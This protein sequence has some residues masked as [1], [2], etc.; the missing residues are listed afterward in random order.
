MHGGNTVN[1]RACGA[2]PRA[3]ARFCDACGT[4]L[5]SAEP[6]AEYKQVTV[7]FAD[8]VRS[9]DLAAEVDPERFRDIMAQVF[10]T[11]AA[12]VTRYGGT[13]DKFTGD[14]VMA[15][16]GA[17]VA[18]EDHASRACRA[19][20]DIQDEAT[21]LAATVRHDLRLRV[22]LN[23]G[24]VIAGDV[25]SRQAGYTAVGQQ[26]GMAQRM[27]SAAPPGGVALS[28]STAHLVRDQAV[29]DGPKM[30]HIK[31]FPDP[32][33]V[34]LLISIGGPLIRNAPDL[35]GRT[36]ELNTLTALLE[37]ATTAAGGLVSVIGPPGIGK[38]RLA[39][40][41]VEIARRHRIDTYVTYCE[42]HT[43]ELAYRTAA[44]MLRAVFGIE[45]LDAA[46]A[47]MA[48]R[49]RLAGADDT[50]IAILFD[51]MGIQPPGTAAPEVP[52]DDRRRRLTEMLNTA[53]LQEREPALMVV[54]DVHWI[55]AASEAM[56]TDFASVL[57]RTRTLLMLTYRPEYHGALRQD[58]T[59][60]A[61]VLNPL[62]DQHVTQ[63]LDGL[64]GGDPSLSEVKER[65]ADQAAGNPF[66]AQE[67]VRDLI[68]RGK[69]QGPPAAYRWS[70]PEY[71]TG[72]PSTLEAVI[73]ARIDRLGPTAKRTLTAAA[74]VGAR[75]DPV[76][77]EHL[78]DDL[79]LDSL[80]Q[81]DLVDR[82]SLLPHVE[83]AFRHPLIR[84]VAY[85][86]QLR[87]DRADLHRR[88]AA[89]IEAEAQTSDDVE[90]DAGLIA[91]HLEAADDLLAA[92][93]WH[94]RAGTWFNTRDIDAARI[95]WRRARDIADRLPPDVE[96][97]NALRIAARVPLTGNAWR[98]GGTVE[99]TGY[100][101]L[102]ELATE[103][104][105][106]RALAVALIGQVAQLALH[107]HLSAANATAAEL[108]DL[109]DELGDEPVTFD[110]MTMT[111]YSL[112]QGGRMDRLYRLTQ[113]LADHCRGDPHLSGMFVP[114]PLVISSALHAVAG[115]ALNAPGWPHDLADVDRIT[116]H[117]DLGIRVIGLTYKYVFLV[118]EGVAPADTAT[119][120]TTAQMLAAAEHLGDGFTLAAARFTHGVMLVHHSDSTVDEGL[121][122]LDLVRSVSAR[123]RFLTSALMTAE[124][125]FA[126]HRLRTGDVSGCVDLARSI[127]DFCVEHGDGILL[128]N[129]T[130]VLVEALL[131]R[132]AAG[133]T[134]SATTAVD[135]FEE[136]CSGYTYQELA[137][138]GMRTRIAKVRGDEP[139]YLDLRD[140]Y[141]RRA[142]ELGFAGHL[143]TAN[144]MR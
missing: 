53:A 37:E 12:V 45:H 118:T 6:T 99:E 81:A 9:M 47:R 122:L 33:A 72:V 28:E 115:C 106:K 131:C 135:R 65:I 79:D 76:V 92:F 31:G 124:A 93:T 136:L 4:A 73:C 89:V 59:G 21:H 2:Q 108:L 101:E 50:A 34:H 16:F 41:A 63:L 64:M 75:F 142:Q 109:V 56:L 52:P 46:T 82:V 104:G 129:I 24:R 111:M 113:R 87:S 97:R 98:V 15:V 132:G 8:V 95:S 133:D 19:A 39:Q 49:E 103:S 32:V 54:E 42:S 5:A 27:E 134:E 61:I 139:T 100:E 86:S 91:E 102:R 17:P 137:L 20:L 114:S 138:L 60:Q 44:M 116:E 130:G 58:R 14:G 96:N 22:G 69:L 112:F 18:L 7:L 110:A 141:R 1:C 123:D 83:Y 105:D 107:H 10:D 80:M 84:T 51:L 125:E 25:G 55:D 30:V 117:T 3:G 140:R 35:V 13:V 23:S 119:I 127:V 71:D 36:W 128:P 67:L 57:P 90:R 11:C 38:S 68:E 78:L 62:R 43:T 121:A 143:A 66:F 120:E 40:E 77:L 144:A 29:L 74:V 94:M 26:V 126:R 88:V 48:I 70:A 85:E